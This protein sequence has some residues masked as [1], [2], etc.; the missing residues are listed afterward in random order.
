MKK[1]ENCE[2]YS[3]VWSGPKLIN[4]KLNLTFDAEGPQEDDQ[5]AG[6]Y[7]S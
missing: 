6:Q 7:P 2:Q 4:L 3:K 1:K 5:L